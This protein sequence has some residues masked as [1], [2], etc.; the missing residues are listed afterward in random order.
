MGRIPLATT[1][2]AATLPGHGDT[3]KE[4]FRRRSGGGFAHQERPQGTHNRHAP[5]PLAPERAASPTP[6]GALWQKHKYLKP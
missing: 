2:S 3:G 5:D 1:C 4:A 6:L